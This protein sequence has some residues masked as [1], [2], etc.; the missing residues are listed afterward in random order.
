MVAG[1]HPEAITVFTREAMKSD[2]AVFSRLR[3]AFMLPIR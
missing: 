2:Y 1:R 3:T